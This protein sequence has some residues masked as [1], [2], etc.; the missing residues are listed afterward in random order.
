MKVLFLGQQGN[1]EP[2]FSDVVD[3]IGGEHDV[4]MFDPE[5]PIPSQ[6]EDVAVVVD[7]GGG[8][9]THATI[10]TAAAAGVKLWQVLGTGLDHVDI[11]YILGRG[12]PLANT[13]GPFSAIALAEH[14]LFFMLYFAK[15]FP[16]THV[17]NGV[18]YQPLN[19]E[20]AGS[21]L[22][23]IGLGASALELAKRAAAFEMSILGLDIAPPSQITR[24]QLGITFVG[25]PE[26][27]HSL[28]AASDYVSVHVP[29]TRQTRHMVDAQALAKMRRD[30]VLINVARGEVVDESALI[31]VLRSHAIRGAGIDVFHDE[32][33]PRTHPF[34]ELDNVVLTP[35]VA[36]VTFGTSRR[37]ARA[38]AE[39]VQRIA[40]GLAP[41][42]SV[43]RAQ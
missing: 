37:R 22:G 13:P 40:A 11:E 26:S 21:T 25:G 34:F 17:R 28:I 36:G 6:L 9:G 43:T 33:L 4:A 15:K 1:L 2:W 23:L 39:N 12:L 14:A 20:L 10:D 16:A 31:E 38:V 30:A 41:L 35:H 32:P 8:R 24:D 19:D 7:Q 27:L 18:F 29:L 3:E 42:Y 5:S